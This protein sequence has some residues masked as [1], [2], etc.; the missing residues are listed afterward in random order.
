MNLASKAVDL[1]VKVG[2]LYRIRQSEGVVT[3]L[4]IIEQSGDE[5]YFYALCTVEHS[6]NVIASRIIKAN[7]FDLARCER[8]GFQEVIPSEVLAN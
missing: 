6:G 4:W 8:A 7:Q 5:G 2:D 3:D 1:P